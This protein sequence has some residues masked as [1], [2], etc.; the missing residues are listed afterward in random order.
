M[1]RQLLYNQVLEHAVVNAQQVLVSAPLHDTAIREHCYRVGV[2]YGGETVCNN[3][4]GPTN[5]QPL[6]CFLYQGLTLRVKGAETE[7]QQS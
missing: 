2:T 4:N 3:N 6:Q 5:H 1:V 7:T